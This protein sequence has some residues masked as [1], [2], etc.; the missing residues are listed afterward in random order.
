MEFDGE[1]KGVS[2]EKAWVV[3][4]DPMAVH[5]SLKECRCITPMNDEFNFDESGAEEGVEML[6]EADPDAVVD[7]AFIAGQKYA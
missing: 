2:P 3:L 7:R 6:P 5:D 4:S 1:L